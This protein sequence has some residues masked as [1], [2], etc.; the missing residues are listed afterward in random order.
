MGLGQNIKNQVEKKID[1]LGDV[2]TFAQ[3]SESY[4]SYD[5]LT[6]SITST[7]TKTG[8]VS[9]QIRKRY[10]L[11]SFG[12]LEEGEIRMLFLADS[13]LE[14]LKGTSYIV[15]YNSGTYLTREEN[16]ISVQG[17]DIVQPIVLVED[18]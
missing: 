7:G 1:L 6:R 15:F 4:N 11:Q 9:N 17:V 14:T 12:K 10:G 8:I 16:A 18:K 5:D 2:V 3:Y 13:N